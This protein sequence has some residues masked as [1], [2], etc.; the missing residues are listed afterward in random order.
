MTSIKKQNGRRT[1][2]NVSFSQYSLNL[3]TPEKLYLG[4][5]Y[6]FFFPK[7]DNFAALIIK[8]GPGCYVWKRDLFHFFLQL[9]LDPID[10]DKVCCIWRGHLLFFTSYVWGTRHAGMNGQ[11]VT[12]A[13]SYIH[14]SLGSSTHCTHKSNGCESDSSHLN[15]NFDDYSPFNTL[16]YCDDFASVE[17]SFVKA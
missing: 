1:V 15:S 16:N 10:F 6:E 7:L 13:V 12:N 9:P 8:Y 5:E 14:R 17:G 2:F 3:N 4:E 11:R